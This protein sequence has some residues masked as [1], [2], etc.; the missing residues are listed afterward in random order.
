MLPQVRGDLVQNT[1]HELC[2]GTQ[3]DSRLGRRMRLRKVPVFA[4]SFP[5]LENARRA[6]HVISIPVSIPKSISVAILPPVQLNMRYPR[7]SSMSYAVLQ[8][9]R[10]LL[11]SAHSPPTPITVV[12]PSTDINPGPDPPHRHAQ[13]PC[14]TLPPHTRKRRRLRLQKT[15]KCRRCRA[16]R[17]QA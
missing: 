8:I 16:G 9:P 13:A 14:P 2:G 12:P 11:P 15:S 1:L 4:K 6:D 17:L 3:L 10:I 5:L 7:S